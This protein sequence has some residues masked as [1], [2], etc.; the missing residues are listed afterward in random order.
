MLSLFGCG[1]GSESP[2][3]LYT[4]T[5]TITNGGTPLTGVA[6]KLTSSDSAVSAGTTDATGTYRLQAT[7]GSY[8]V[9]PADSTWG[10]TPFAVTINGRNAT[11]PAITTVFP[12]YTLTGKITKGGTP[13][14]GIAVSLNGARVDIVT[15][16]G[17]SGGTV[18]DLTTVTGSSRVSPVTTTT[19]A[20]GSYTF[21]G[22][23]AGCY[24]VSPSSA[25]Y[26]FNPL[27]TKA[28]TITSTQVYL[29]DKERGGNSLTPDSSIIY[30]ST[31][32]YTG[33]SINIQDFTAEVK[34]P[35]NI[36]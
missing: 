31:L 9:N 15:T 10:F 35:L 26:N 34:N 27:I 23:K 18:V 3:V 20:D 12:V 25:A 17:L 7:N 6:V 16:D 8:M 32:Q 5:G 28:F 30:N 2:P 33:N 14:A 29:Y 24:L 21:N 22:T 1:G 19:E 4:I 11:A 36:L 13:L